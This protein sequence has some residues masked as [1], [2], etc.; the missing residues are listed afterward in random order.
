MKCIDL[1]DTSGELKLE[2]WIYIVFIFYTLFIMEARFIG[3][4]KHH[5]FPN[6]YRLLAG[7]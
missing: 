1:D 5:F 2:S 6:L 7:V 4:R 3:K